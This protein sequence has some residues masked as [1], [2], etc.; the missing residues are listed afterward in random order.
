MTLIM[1]K[2][3]WQWV[4]PVTGIIVSALILVSTWSLLRKSM[5]L[6]LDDRSATRSSRGNLH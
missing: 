3:G 1:L 4:D 5:D 2:T 6:V